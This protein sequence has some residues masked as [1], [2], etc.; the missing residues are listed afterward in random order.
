MALKRY[1]RSR[2]TKRT[3]K[4]NRRAALPRRNIK[5]NTMFCKRHVHL[6]TVGTTVAGGWQA[7]PYVFSLNQLPAF[8][9]FVSLFDAYKINAVKLTFTPFWDSNDMNQNGPVYTINPRVYTVVDRNGFPAGS[10]ASEALFHE[11]SKCRLI[12]KPMEPF[13]I[14]I[15][16][17]GLE[18]PGS[19]GGG[20]TG[21]GVNFSRKWIDTSVPAMNYNGAAIGITIPAGS[22]TAGFYYNVVATYYLQFKNVV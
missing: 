21:I 15:K 20:F 2:R 3:R 7:F 6:G 19:T 14:F 22:P 4:Y 12:T 11:Q 10:I 9:E 16:A 5:M 18:I 17:P 1:R 13:S 8:S